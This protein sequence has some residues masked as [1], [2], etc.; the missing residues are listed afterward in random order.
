MKLPH[1]AVRSKLS[2]QCIVEV[3]EEDLAYFQNLAFLD[4][5]DNCVRL[6]QLANLTG[7]SELNL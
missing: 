4:L 5:S 3:V 7:L 2:G 6:E 1:E